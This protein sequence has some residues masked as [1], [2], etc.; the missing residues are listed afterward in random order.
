MDRLGLL[1]LFSAALFAVLH[2][3]FR[4]LLLHAIALR[5]SQPDRYRGFWRALGG[6]APSGALSS[7]RA[8]TIAMVVG[9]A[10]VAVLALT[11]ALDVLVRTSEGPLVAALGLGLVNVAGL[12][13][14]LLVI[15]RGRRQP[16]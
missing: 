16:R 6:L 1:L 8:T 4:A 15:R 13:A 14:A 7:L 3:T 12:L 9:F 10:L 2:I 5:A 11:D